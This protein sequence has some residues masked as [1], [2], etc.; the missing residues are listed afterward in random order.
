MAVA[1]VLATPVGSV[2]ICMPT[3]LM[4]HGRLPLGPQDSLAACKRLSTAVRNQQ[5]GLETGKLHLAARV[6]LLQRVEA[7]PSNLRLGGIGTF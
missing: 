6:E 4:V 7:G 5:D 2:G 3:L 1:E